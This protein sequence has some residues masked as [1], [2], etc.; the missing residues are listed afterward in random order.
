VIAAIKVRLPLNVELSVSRTLTVQ[1]LVGDLADAGF[2]TLLRDV[3]SVPSHHP[4]QDLLIVTLSHRLQR[5][6]VISQAISNKLFSTPSAP[7][8]RSAMVFVA[9]EICP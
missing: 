1:V 7:G 4:G 5:P 2:F 3:T 6:A 9:L 8:P